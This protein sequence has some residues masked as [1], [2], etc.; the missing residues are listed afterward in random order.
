MFHRVKEDKAAFHLMYSDLGLNDERVLKKSKK[1]L[2]HDLVMAFKCNP[3]ALTKGAPVQ[4][5]LSATNVKTYC[6]LN[7]H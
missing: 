1:I 2:S 5:I 7:A 4:T 3:F 6:K